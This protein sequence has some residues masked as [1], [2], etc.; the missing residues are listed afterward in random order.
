MV[1]TTGHIIGIDGMPSVMLFAECI[2]SE[3][4]QTT[5]CRVCQKNTWQT[6]SLPSVYTL[7]RFCHVYITTAVNGRLAAELSLPSIF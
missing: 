4:R 2:L 1:K 3:T 5:L 6:S 7:Q